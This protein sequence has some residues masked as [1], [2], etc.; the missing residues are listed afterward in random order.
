M[1]GQVNRKNRKMKPFYI[2]IA[3]IFS[4]LFAQAVSA[5]SISTPI[6]AATYHKESTFTVPVLLASP[7]QAINAFE[8]TVTYPDNLVFVGSDEGGSIISFW[9]DKP[10]SENASSKNT[11]NSIVFSGAMPSGFTEVYNPLNKKKSPG[12][13]TKLIFKAKQEGSGTIAATSALYA[14]DGFGTAV[15]ATGFS[16]SIAVDETTE[17][18]DYVWSDVVPPEL[19]VPS[20]SKDDSIYGGKYALYF[21]AI[22]KDSGIAGYEV[23]E[24]ER[25]WKAATSPYLLQDQQLHSAIT[26]R[27]TD[28]AG[29]AIIATLEAP[30][31][32]ANHFAQ[33][34]MVYLLIFIL[35]SLVFVFRKRIFKVQ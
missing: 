9:I 16:V 24:G 3:F 30:A 6:A 15:P 22:D 31:G 8:V 27:A 18:T 20:V 23:R 28:K 4:F 32:A 33:S 35:L 5:Q 25:K 17:A 19:F 26:V 1:A 21:N 2:T 14:N 12:L 7:D 10:S 11:P 34:L 13:L 29:N